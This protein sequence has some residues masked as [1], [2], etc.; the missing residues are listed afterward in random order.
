MDSRF[1][2]MIGKEII[3]I[4]NQWR[5]L[6]V[7]DLLE[8]KK[9]GFE[10]IYCVYDSWEDFTKTYIELD[11][12]NITHGLEYLIECVD[13]KKATKYISEKLKDDYVQLKSGKV[14]QGR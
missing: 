12:K 7:D 1:E 13:I 9:I 3:S 11:K 14:I 5:M 10:V 4:A 6:T 8:I 2:Q